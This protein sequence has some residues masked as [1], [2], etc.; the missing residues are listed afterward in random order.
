MYLPWSLSEG[1]VN[2]DGTISTAEQTIVQNAV[3]NWRTNINST[4]NSLVLLHSLGKSSPGAPDP[5][6]SLTVSNVVG[7]QRRRLGR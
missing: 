1:N 4:G 7:T 5:V 6:T 2:E 3:T